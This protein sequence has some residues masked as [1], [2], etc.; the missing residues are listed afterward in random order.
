[1]EIFKKIK[2]LISRED[3]VVYKLRGYL[4]KLYEG[5]P[6]HFFFNYEKDTALADGMYA[7]IE[8]GIIK[9]EQNE[10]EGRYGYRLTANGLRLV[11]VWKNERLVRVG[12]IL[13]LMVLVVSIIHLL[14]I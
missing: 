12:I 9:K 10:D 8:D 6:T 11:E 3:F 1:M 7:L 14:W 4:N 13:T 5:Y 2:K